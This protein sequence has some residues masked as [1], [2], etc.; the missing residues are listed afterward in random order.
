MEFIV[1]GCFLGI[2]IGGFLGLMFTVNMRNKAIKIITICFCIVIS[3]L[4]FTVMFKSESDNFNNGYCP[5]CETKYEAIQRK[6]S[7]TYYEC[8]NCYYGTW[9]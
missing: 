4:I 6:N 7:Q 3:S 2:I 9:Y 5:Y 1:G 8:P